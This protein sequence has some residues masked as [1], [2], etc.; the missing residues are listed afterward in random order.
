MLRIFMSICAFLCLTMAGGVN[1]CLA[2]DGSVVGGYMASLAPSAANT[3]GTT[4]TAVFKLTDKKGGLVGSFWFSQI[5]GVSTYGGVSVYFLPAQENTV[6]AWNNAERIPIMLNENCLSGETSIPKEFSAPATKY[7]RF[8]Y[9]V[10]QTI[11]RPTGTGEGGVTF[12]GHAFLVDATQG[13]DVAAVRTGPTQ[14]FIINASSGT[15][16][17]TIPDGTRKLIVSLR[18]DD[19]VWRPDGTNPTATDGY[20]LSQGDYLILDSNE[21]ADNFRFGLASG[22]TGASVYATPYTK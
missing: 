22:G 9:E 20:T 2:Y 7:G 8:E 15:S 17:V 12:Y 10:Q 4:Q 11:A 6:N 1:P 14:T 16:S 19:I 5:G 3:T 21:Q 18:G 13:I